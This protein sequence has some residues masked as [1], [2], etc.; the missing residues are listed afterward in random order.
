MN[1]QLMAL[2]GV[3]W[4]PS[5][6]LA[7]EDAFGLGDG[8]LGAFTVQRADTV[9]NAYASVHSGPARDILILSLTPHCSRPRTW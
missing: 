7:Q 8:H 4:F 5:G 3:L 1:R 2:V 6:A 9:I